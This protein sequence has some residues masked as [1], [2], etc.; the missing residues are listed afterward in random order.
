MCLSGATGIPGTGKY[1]PGG[2]GAIAGVN[3]GDPLD[4]FGG[5]RRRDAARAEQ[6]ARDAE[7]AR[8]AGIDKN[9]KDINS[10]YAGREPQYA[11]FGDALRQRLNSQ[12]D[13]QRKN[14]TRQTKFSLARSGTT[15]GSAAIDAGRTLNREATEGALAAER[16]AQSGVAGLRS[17]DEDARLKLIGMAQSG[18]NIGNG[19]E[20]AAQLL[21]ANLQNAQSNNTAGAL[22]DVFNAT[23]GAYRQ[24]QDNAAFLRGL[25]ASNP[26]GQSNPA[27]SGIVGPR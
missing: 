11:Q 25:R 5:Q 12:L 7:T 24:N 27:N 4:L 8:Q 19:T 26:Y 16:Q 13:L 1:A 15:G 22:G 2:A 20:Q 18:A 21:S 17:A 9:V 6:E 14:A 3:V 10:A 23:T